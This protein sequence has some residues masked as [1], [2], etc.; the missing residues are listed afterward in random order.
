[1]SYFGRLGEQ[2]LEDLNRGTP[3]YF[4]GLHDAGEDRDILRSVGAARPEANLAK[5]DQR[6]QRA[7]RVVVGGRSPTACE[8]K[9]LLVFAR[10]G[11]EPF[12]QCFGKGVRERKPY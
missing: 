1:M 9:D 6:P 10:S 3:P 5:D 4:C 2:C 7:F 8:G 12:A 11:E